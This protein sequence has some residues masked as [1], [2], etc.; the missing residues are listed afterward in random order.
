MLPTKQMVEIAQSV[1]EIANAYESNHFTEESLNNFLFQETLN[2]PDV[3]FDVEKIAEIAR[4]YVD[5]DVINS[6]DE[7]TNKNMWFLMIF[8]KSSLFLSPSVRCSSKM[9]SR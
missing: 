1:A 5:E 2:M 8:R 6:I 4:D 3:E 7:E 9:A